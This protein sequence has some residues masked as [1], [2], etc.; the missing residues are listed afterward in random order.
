M[1]DHLTDPGAVLVID[2]TWH[3]EKGTATVGVHRQYIGTAG[4]I[5]NAQVAVYLTYAAPAGARAGRPGPVPAHV[6]VR[7]P[8]RRTRAGVPDDIKFA[9]KPQLASDDRPRPRREGAGQWVA[10][11]EVYGGDPRLRRK[12]RG[13]GLGYV[14]QIASTRQ[15]TTRAG[16]VAVRDLA[17]AMRA[18]A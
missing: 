6:L 4:R 16:R 13:H 15:V 10:G 9:T 7:R 18:T 8:D 12:I 5:E 2:E 17:A 1:L 11:D 3:L 14:M